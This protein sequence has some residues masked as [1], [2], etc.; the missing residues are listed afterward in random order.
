MLESLL[1]TASGDGQPGLV[2]TEHYIFEDFRSSD[3]KV[4]LYDLTLP[5]PEQRLRIS[6]L[7]NDNKS[8][9]KVV[10]KLAASKASLEGII[11]P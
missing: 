5:P 11:E 10:I 3:P 8:S 1:T 7:F 9:F 6:V 4:L 2:G